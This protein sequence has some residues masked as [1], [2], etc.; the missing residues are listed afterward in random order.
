MTGRLRDGFDCTSDIISVVNNSCLFI[1]SILRSLVLFSNFLYHYLGTLKIRKKRYANSRPGLLGIL[2]LK[3]LGK[4]RDRSEKEINLVLTTF[5]DPKSSTF[6]K[7]GNRTDF[8][9]EN[10]QKGRR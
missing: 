2:I 10:M 9:R 7:D 3:R 5:K 4:G 8:K 6:D 1:L